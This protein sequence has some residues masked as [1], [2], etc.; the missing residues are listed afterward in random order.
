[1]Q[2]EELVIGTL[3]LYE[4]MPVRLVRTRCFDTPEGH[5]TTAIIETVAYPLLWVKPEELEPCDDL[6]KAIDVC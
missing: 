3:Y 5:K 2:A 6:L 4:G 1:M